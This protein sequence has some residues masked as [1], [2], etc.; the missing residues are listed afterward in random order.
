MSFAD[1]EATIRELRADVDVLTS[2]RAVMRSRLL[3]A[4][5]MAGLPDDIAPAAIPDA[6]ACEVARLRADVAAYVSALNEAARMAC[7]PSEIKPLAIPR[8]LAV[9]HEHMRAY[10]EGLERQLKSARSNAVEY[11]DTIAA[12]RADVAAMLQ[13]GRAHV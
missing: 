1:D 13:I 11:L 3:G 8:E 5:T 10:A 4:A 6:L 2:E 12:L 9:S 7:V